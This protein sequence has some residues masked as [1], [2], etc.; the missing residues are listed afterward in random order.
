MY[1]VDEFTSTWEIMCLIV[2][3]L[4]RHPDCALFLHPVDEV[5]HDVPGYYAVI[6]HPMDLGTIRTKLQ[7]NS[8]PSLESFV[9]L[10]RLVFH[11][12]V[13]YNKPGDP[14]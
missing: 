3:Q 12:A 5:M 11:N 7:S 8:I 1:H 10:V 2:I 9:Q 6:K 4:M 14:V 13:L